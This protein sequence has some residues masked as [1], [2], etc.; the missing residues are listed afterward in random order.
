MITKKQDL[1]R[2]I[3]DDED[4][5]DFSENSDEEV[6]FQPSKK[7]DKVNLDFDTGFNFV[8]S[9]SEYN[10]DAWDDL[11]KYIKRKAKSK[12]DDKIQKLRKSN[13]KGV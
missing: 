12:V 10:H 9:I 11:S 13:S 5:P 8:S 3:E 4:V 6:E 1:I 2:T 7:K